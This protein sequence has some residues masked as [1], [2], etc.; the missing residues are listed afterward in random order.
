MYKRLLYKPLLIR[1]KEPLKFIQVLMGPRQAGKTTL[2]QQLL[3]DLGMDYVFESADAV[4][5]DSVWLEQIWER[6]RI[7]AGSEKGRECLLIIDGIQKIRNGNESVK[8]SWDEDTRKKRDLKALLLG[9][10]RLLFRQGLTESLA[11]RFENTYLGS[12][13]N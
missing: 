2:V 8:K 12:L 1:L 3:P 4:G 10:S 11:G 13:W 7:N 5:S 6:A 9:S